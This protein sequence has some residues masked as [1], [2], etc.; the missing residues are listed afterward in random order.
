MFNQRSK[1]LFIGTIIATIYGIY[2]ISYFNSAN[3]TSQSDAEAVGAAIA[4]ALVAPHLAM[5]WLGVVFGWFGFF[6]KKAWGALVSAIFYSVAAVLFFMYAL[7]VIPSII[8]GFMGYSKQHKL[9]KKDNI[10]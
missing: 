6:A 5:V 2:L 10:K 4:T 7:F 1:S 3:S 8:L 9:N